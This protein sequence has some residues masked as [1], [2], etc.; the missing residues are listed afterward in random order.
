VA[1][2]TLERHLASLREQLREQTI[3]RCEEDLYE[4]VKVFWHIVEPVNPLIEG[5]VMECICQH[6]QAVTENQA[7]RVIIN[8]PPGCSKS[9]LSCVFFPAWEWGPRN[10]PSM[11]YAAFS[12]TSTLT[13]RDNGRM[14]QLI[15]SDLYRDYWGDRFT[16]HGG[17]VKVKNDHTGWKLATSIAGVGTGERADRLLLDDLNNVK[18]SESKAILENTNKWIREVMPTRL[19]HLSRSAVIN[20]QQRTNEDDATGT[21][22][23][24]RDDWIWVMIPMRHESLRHCITGIGWSDPRIE[25]G[26]LCWPERFPPT[27]I[28]PLEREMGPYAWAGQMQQS[29]SPRGGGIIKTDWWQPWAVAVSPPLDYIV[30]TLDTGMTAKDSS[31]PSAMIVL[32]SFQDHGSIVGDEFQ[33]Y[34]FVSSSDPGGG[35]ERALIT[36][37]G[38]PKIFMA[39]AWQDR[40]SLPDLVDRVLLTH[41][42][43]KFDTLVIENKTHGHAVNQTLREMFAKAPFSIAMYDPRRYGDKSARLYSVQHLFSE[44]LIFAPGKWIDGI[45]S[46]KEWADDVIRQIG[47]FPNA[48]HDEFVDCMSMGLQHL[49]ARGFAPRREDAVDQIINPLRHGGRSR[50]LYSA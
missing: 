13:E 41:R 37:G 18:E 10:M 17:E 27:E 11:R 22:V 3:R 6:L 15:N 31:D 9:L 19:N 35:R 25:E 30:A 20:I 2:P 46:W 28:A 24:N 48:G 8:V 14:M 42:K 38:V 45:W 23:A 39:H 47:A 40:L 29:P 33:G 50:P 4:F 44:E 12:Y 32:G 21:L 26:E 1:H 7:Q 34:D 5:W 16:V 43:T 49:R 36:Q